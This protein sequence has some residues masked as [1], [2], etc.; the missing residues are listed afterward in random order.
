MDFSGPVMA[1]SNN[2]GGA[3]S[4]RLIKDTH[5]PLITLIGESTKTVD[6]G[7]SYVDQGATATDSE[8]GDITSSIKVVSDVDISTVGTYT[9]RYSVKTPDGCKAIP[10]TRTVIVENIN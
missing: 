2:L 6:V 9:V 10:I 7:D 3:N 5:T 8:Y 1:L 4:I